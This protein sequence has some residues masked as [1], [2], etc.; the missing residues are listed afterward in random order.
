MLHKNFSAKESYV[1]NKK[2]QP[3]TFVPHGVGKFFIH[4]FFSTDKGSSGSELVLLFKNILPVC[5]Q[6]FS[7]VLVRTLVWQ[8]MKL[9]ML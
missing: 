4:F 8:D 5:I 3:L 7:C 6:A 1:K 2:Q 9:E